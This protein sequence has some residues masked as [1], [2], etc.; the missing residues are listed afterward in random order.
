MTNETKAKAARIPQAKVEEAR[1]ALISDAISR[2]FSGDSSAQNATEQVL[3]LLKL[4]GRMAVE[5]AE[6][7]GLKAEQ[8]VKPNE[9]DR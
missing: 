3:R 5:M 6:F 2:H 7:Q 9:T 1:A 4:P 8:E